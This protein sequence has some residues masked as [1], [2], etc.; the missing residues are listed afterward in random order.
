MKSVNIPD[1]MDAGTTITGFGGQEITPAQLRALLNVPTIPPNTQV[2]SGAANTITNNTSIRKTVLIASDVEEAVA[3]MVVRGKNGAR[4][5]IGANGPAGTPGGPRG[6]PIALVADPA[7][8]PTPMIVRGPR[9]FQGIQGPLGVA[10]RSKIWLPEEFPDEPMFT[11]RAKA[12][13][14]VVVAATTLAQAILADSPFAF[15]KCDDA[16]TSLADSSGNGFSLTTAVGAP[17]FQSGPLVPSLPASQF[18]NFSGYTVTTLANGF[19]LTSTL[20]RTFPFTQWT[21][22]FVVSMFGQASGI[23]R[24]IDWRTSGTT[25][26]LALYNNGGPLSMALNNTNTALLQTGIFQIGKPYH[27]VVTCST[28]AGTSTITC[29][30]NGVRY[31]A[32]VT[33]AAS[34]A[35][36]RNIYCRAGGLLHLRWHNCRSDRRV[37]GSLL[38][39][40]FSSPYWCPRSS[41]RAIRC[42]M[43]YTRSNWRGQHAQHED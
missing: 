18:V 42:L 13:A 33:A 40:P 34:T 22:E 6:F 3:P 8:P 10:S 35:S 43:Y 39:D 2:P 16:S 4:G 25:A 5:P 28:T 38:I 20:G 37:C 21:A 7:E 41:R 9:G 11:G 1:A 30:V 32:P 36:G 26:V 15:W 27:I 23:V 31:G 29:W 19:Q 12:G 17:T 14:G 24:I